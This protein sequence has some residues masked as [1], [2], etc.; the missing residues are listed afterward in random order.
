MLQ[1]DYEI[2]FLSVV[3]VQYSIAKNEKKLCIT[4]FAYPIVNDTYS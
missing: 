1:P 3:K 2:I 4:G